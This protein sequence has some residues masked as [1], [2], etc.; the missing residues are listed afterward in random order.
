[1][2]ALLFFLI[3]FAI[4]KLVTAIRGNDMPQVLIW[5]VATLV[6]IVVGLTGHLGVIHA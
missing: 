1:M 5:G 3:V 2:T 4:A 6:L